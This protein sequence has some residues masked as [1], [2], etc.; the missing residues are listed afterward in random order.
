MNE[1]PR[2]ALGQLTLARLRLF[3]REPEAVFW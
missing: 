2:S 3:L 1:A